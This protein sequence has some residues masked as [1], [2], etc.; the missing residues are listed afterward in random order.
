MTAKLTSSET[1]VERKPPNIVLIQSHSAQLHVE[2]SL[3]N[4]QENLHDSQ[5]HQQ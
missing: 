4:T 1:M 3:E 2:W 5:A